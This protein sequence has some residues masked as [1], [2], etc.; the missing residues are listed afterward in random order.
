MINVFNLFSLF[1]VSC[2]QVRDFYI[3]TKENQFKNKIILFLYFI[4]KTRINIHVYNSTSSFTK[5]VGRLMKNI[6][7][8]ISIMVLSD[9][10]LMLHQLSKRFQHDRVIDLSRSKSRMKICSLCDFFL[11]WV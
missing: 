4:I 9:N 3:E 10:Y 5:Y 1:M 8:S 2:L 6:S 7:I 11:Y